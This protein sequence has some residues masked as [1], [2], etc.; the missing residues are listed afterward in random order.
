MSKQ[1]IAYVIRMQLKQ[2]LPRPTLFVGGDSETDG[3]GN[4]NNTTSVTSPSLSASKHVPGT[5]DTAVMA[6]PTLPDDLAQDDFYCQVFSARKGGGGL[7]TTGVNSNASALSTLHPLPVSPY[8]HADGSPKLPEGTL[9]RIAASS[10]RKPKKLM[11]LTGAP[12]V[13]AAT[14][15]ATPTGKEKEPE[16]VEE[17]TDSGYVFF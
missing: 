10:L 8:R 9:G 7:I 13:D 14:A 2:L 4:G 6:P 17:P 12:A 3:N 16:K 15:T 1:E 11:S 5:G